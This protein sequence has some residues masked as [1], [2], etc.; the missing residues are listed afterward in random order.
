MRS[1]ETTAKVS[2]QR[3][4]IGEIAKATGFTVRA[5]RHYEEIGL[6]SPSSRSASGQRLYGPQSVE[7]L[8]RISALQR[9]GLSLTQVQTALAENQTDAVTLIGDHLRAV[10][11]RLVVENRLRSRLVQVVQTLGNDEDATRDLMSILEDMNMTESLLERRIAILVYE[12]IEAACDYL[13]RV[14]GFGAG[15]ITRDPDGTVVHGEVQAGDGEFWLHLESEEYNL[16]S[17][18]NLGSAT[19]TMAVM[20]EDVDAHHERAAAE[21]AEVR[22]EPI[23]QP[24]GYREY[25]AVDCEGHLWSFMKPLPDAVTA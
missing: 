13:T 23:D 8:Y 18:K 20:V 12:D 21:G 24:Y 15:E 11:E 16:Q 7:Q 6:L 17:P 10:E 19:A 14:F 22:Y 3:W 9:L 25:S 5:L 2:D 1:D 4:R